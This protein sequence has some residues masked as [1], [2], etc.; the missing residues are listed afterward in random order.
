MLRKARH[1]VPWLVTLTLA[2]ACGA[3]GPS[4]AAQATASAAAVLPWQSGM[5]A[6]GNGGTIEP[7]V[8]D[9]DGS[10]TFLLTPIVVLFASHQPSYPTGMQYLRETLLACGVVFTFSVLS[11]WVLWTLR[12][13]AGRVTA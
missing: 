12:P 5:R 7:A 3:Q 9:T 8:S 1:I 4:D 2:V 6:T 11:K 10:Q 13:D